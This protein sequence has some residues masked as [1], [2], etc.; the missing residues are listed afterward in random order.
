MALEETTGEQ[1]LVNQKMTGETTAEEL[2]VNAEHIFN[3]R[4]KTKTKKV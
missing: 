1:T 2:M 3:H 4:T